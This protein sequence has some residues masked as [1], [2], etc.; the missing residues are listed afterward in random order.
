MGAHMVHLMCTARGASNARA[1]QVLGW[2][3]SFAS[4]REG[5]AQLSTVS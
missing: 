4:W 3:P 5:F 2:E 1:K